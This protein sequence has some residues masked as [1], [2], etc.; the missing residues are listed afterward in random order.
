MSVNR[1]R[2]TRYIRNGHET[3]PDGV[4]SSDSGCPKDDVYDQAARRR[5]YPDDPGGCR[6]HGAVV[7]PI[8]AIRRPTG[9]CGRLTF[10]VFPLWS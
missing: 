9:R 2:W 7:L 10:L 5:H 4:A 1:G 8:P 3:K 6:C